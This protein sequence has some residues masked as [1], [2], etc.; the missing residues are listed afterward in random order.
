MNVPGFIARRYLLAKK[1]RNIINLIN[2]ISVLGILVS[3]AALVVLLSIFNGIEDMVL[4]LYTDFDPAITIRSAKAKTFNE[5][6]IDLDQI[7]AIEGVEIISR[8]VE[9]V[10]ILKHEQKWVH[11]KMLGVD[12]TFITMAKIKEHLID[13]D[14][15]LYDG[16]VPLAI[17]G[18]G[19]L[20]KLDGYIPHHNYGREQIIFHVPLRDGKFRPGRN[21]LN[22]RPVEVAA[23]VNYNREVNYQYVVVPFDLARELLNYDHDISSIFIHAKPGVNLQRLKTAIAQHLGA[24]FE[25][26]TNFEK[27]ELIFKT[28]QSERVIVFIILLFIFLLSS[29]NLIASLIMM[30]VEKRKDMKTLSAIGASQHMIF[31]IFF[32]QGL[33]ISGVG[34][35][36]GLAIGYAICFAHLQFGIVEMP[37]SGGEYLPLKVTTK[38]ALFIITSVSLLGFLASYLPSKYLTSRTNL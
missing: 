32:F 34:I 4:K 5:T 21:P 24:D 2:G 13:G 38:D 15:I 14:P 22:I 35:I 27:N 31:R 3:T 20:D 26:K 36:M 11:A 9:E 10:V 30:Y 6:F 1:S 16:E 12:S 25:V 33:M 18:A 17:F 29:V 28:S 8:A 7:Q 37:N 23:R 19:V